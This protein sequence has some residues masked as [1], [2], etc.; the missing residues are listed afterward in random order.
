MSSTER[1]F[2]LKD[3]A[4]AWQDG[5]EEGFDTGEAGAL[6]RDATDLKYPKDNPYL[7]KEE[8]C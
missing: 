3:M 7:K 5:W 2:T 6:G 4:Q 1:L 8:S